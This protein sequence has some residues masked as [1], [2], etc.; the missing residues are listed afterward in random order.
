MLTPFLRVWRP[1][2]WARQVTS[3]PNAC[4]RWKG[5]RQVQKLMDADSGCI[6]TTQSCSRQSRLG[7]AALSWASLSLSVAVRLLCKFGGGGEIRT[8]GGLPH[9]GFQDRHLKPLGHPS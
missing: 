2:I 3:A 5:A 4:V 1:G 7:P 6:M 8:R 9:N